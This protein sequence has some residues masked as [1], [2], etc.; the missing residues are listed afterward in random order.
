[1]CNNDASKSSI[2]STKEA[3]G[4]SEAG[5]GI[6]VGFSGIIDAASL[7]GVYVVV[8]NAFSPYFGDCDLLIS[9]NILSRDGFVYPTKQRLVAVSSMRLSG[10]VAIRP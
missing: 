9:Q 3:D 1:V 4:S 5:S 8:L 7:A 10:D 2:S 6:S